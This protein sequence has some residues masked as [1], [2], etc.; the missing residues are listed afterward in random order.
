M[1]QTLAIV[2]ACLLTACGAQ[3]TSHSS[4]PPSPSPAAA[5]STPSPTVSP[6]P[7]ET[8]APTSQP[9]VSTPRPTP[10]PTPR[11]TAPPMMASSVKIMNF[12]FTPSSLSVRRGAR[13]TF[14]NKDA[15]THTVTA[16]GGLFDSGN[17]S[18]DQTF[19]FTFMG[20]GS[21]AY[22]CKIHTSMRATITV[23]T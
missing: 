5:S 20:T 18:A 13:V 12:A 15:S 19:S 23:T 4:P 16:D 17:L 22:H 9:V 2:V 6:A 11:P 3:A 1:R 14:T 21:F 10:A 7:V 8:P